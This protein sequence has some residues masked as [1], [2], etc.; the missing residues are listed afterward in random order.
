MNPKTLSGKLV[1]NSVALGLT[2]LA[3]SASADLVVN[4]GG[5]YVAANVI[6]AR[7]NTANAF[8]YP[9]G[10][11]RS[12]VLAWSEST[13]LNPASGYSG[14]S[15]SFYGGYFD[16]HDGTL[17]TA[18]NITATARITDSGV[19][20]QLYY[21]FQTPA[22]ANKTTVQVGGGISWLKAD[23]LSLSDTTIALDASSSL[24]M[25]IV[26]L[27]TSAPASQPAPAVRWMIKDG[28]QWYVSSTSYTTTGSK[29]L[30]GASLLSETWLT[31][32]PA[33]SL[34]EPTG[35]YATHDFADI[36]AVGYFGWVTLSTAAASTTDIV[37]NGFAANFT[38]A[39]VP[40]P[41]TVTLALAGVAMLL[42]SRRRRAK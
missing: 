2:L 39:A 19:T 4:W 32:N 36:T 29:S 14:T 8:A 30:S 27:T 25:N 35:T 33:S 17:T 40:E 28:A 12:K 21:R 3:T 9:S 20:D 31:F 24:S 26:T 13:L 34:F 10:T 37:L 42:V 11:G 7:A 18:A 5:N 1:C 6:Y 41:S 16:S 15:A 38:A 23:F 22:D